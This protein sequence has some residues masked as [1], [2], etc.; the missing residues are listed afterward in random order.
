MVTGSMFSLQNIF[1]APSDT[2]SPDCCL[3][4][5]SVVSHQDCSGSYSHLLSSES[6]GQPL[7]LAA[8]TSPKIVLSSEREKDR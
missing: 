6:F 8:L 1:N 4:R 7:N 5:V 2:D 3:H